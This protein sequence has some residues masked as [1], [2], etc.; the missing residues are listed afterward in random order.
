MAAVLGCYARLDKVKLKMIQGGASCAGY[1]FAELQDPQAAQI[2]VSLSN[3][4]V[5]QGTL[6]SI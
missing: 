2:L 1:G 6:I 5:F 3:T 4:L